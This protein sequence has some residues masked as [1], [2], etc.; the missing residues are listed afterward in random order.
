MK[1]RIPAA[2]TL[3]EKDDKSSSGDKNKQKSKPRNNSKRSNI[4]IWTIKIIVITLFL[5]CFFSYISE[6]TATYAHV[7]ISFILLITLICINILFDAVAIATTSCDLP[8]LLAM[9]SRK[10]KG[11]RIAVKLVKNAERVS[12]ICGDVIGDICGIISGACTAAILLKT[13]GEGTGA[14]SL[15]FWISIIC[16]GIVAALTVG[17]KAIVKVF[18]VKK[19]K[20]VVLFV[21]KVLSVFSKNK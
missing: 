20:E 7:A 14:G 6:L 21:S 10:I 5:S 9:A 2:H 8:P 4:T 19:S 17:G 1:Y 11:G 16:S 15:P 12:S 3:K 18:A 13:I